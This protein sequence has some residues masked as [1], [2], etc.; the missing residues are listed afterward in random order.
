MEHA[1]AQTVVVCAALGVTNSARSTKTTQNLAQRGYKDVCVW[2]KEREGR[3]KLRREL[4]STFATVI[5]AR[6]ERKKTFPV[7]FP[8][9]RICFEGKR[10]I[11]GE[12]ATRRPRRWR[13]NNRF[14]PLSD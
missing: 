11:S 13:G 14:R 1:A 3:R 2:L 10:R 7:L 12:K 5:S 6:V 4:V 8:Q 9:T